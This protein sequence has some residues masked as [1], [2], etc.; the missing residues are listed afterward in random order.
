ML[1]RE[2]DENEE[3]SGEDENDSDEDYGYDPGV[4]TEKESQWNRDL[5]CL[6]LD[7]KSTSLGKTF[8]SGIGTCGVY[9]GANIGDDFFSTY[10]DSFAENPVYPV[11]PKC[12]DL[13]RLLVAHK[14]GTGA[15]PVSVDGSW[16]PRSLDLD[17]GT[18]FAIL[19]ERSNR[20][21]CL[22]MDYGDPEIDHNEQFWESRQGEE[23][24]IADPTLD[25]EL[26]K[27]M[28][29]SV[30]HDADNQPLT[31]NTALFAK[32]EDSNDLFAKLPFELLLNVISELEASSLLSLLNASPHV[33]RALD[34][35]SS[36]WLNCIGKSMPWF[37]ELH[38]FLDN[39]TGSNDDGRGNASSNADAFRDKSLRRFFVWANHITTPRVGQMGPFMCVANRRR[40][41][42]V[43][44]QLVDP[45]LAQL[46]S[47]DAV[48]EDASE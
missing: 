48:I 11:H 13:F 43:C 5:Q 14:S 31:G 23:L 38:E 47:P 3:E 15:T 45:Y 25:D 40:I 34:S 7:L 16:I 33:H 29:L 1:Q 20:F 46:Q 42:D 2:V 30:W 26:V 12:L 6:G 28:I 44:Q 8:L 22:E 17:T 4:I 21:N 41:W 10:S 37:F 35:G 9:G 36:L 32:T 27:G 24:F 18:L 19:D 39:L